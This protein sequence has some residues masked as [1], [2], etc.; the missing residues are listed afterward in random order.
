[1][2]M[3]Y[4]RSQLF[5]ALLCGAAA[6]GH[7][8]VPTTIIVPYPAGGAVDVL[9][10][11]LS[12]KM[13]ETSG[14]VFVIDNRPGS[15]GLI[16]AMA[17]AQAKPDGKTWLLG[18]D[19]LLTVNPFLYPKD[20]AFT[21]DKDLLVVRGLAQQQA[22]LFV[23]PGFPAKTMKE[24]VD[25]ARKNEVTYA[26]AGNGS[27]AHLTMELLGSAT[28]I[29]LLHVPY[30]GGNLAMIDVIAG[31]VQAS[32]AAVP[33]AIEHVKAGKVTPLAVAAG[34]RAAQLPNVPTTAEA[35]FPGLAAETAVFMMLPAGV[36]AD[37]V[38]KVNRTIAMALADAGVRERIVG[39]GWLPRPDMDTPMAQQWLARTTAI[40]S[41]LIPEKG[42]KAE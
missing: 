23:Y 40:W 11:I 10:R 25:Y 29:K 39:T 41:K 35:G 36:P 4:V 3:K 20:R 27:P 33:V 28:G 34:T 21:A 12:Q 13:T 32:F 16:G 37:T 8:Q 31:R 38:A 17:A 7:A 22:L 42:I 19:A 9:A 18:G 26:S 2:N 6:F 14:E 5:A 24:F 30:K 15:N 1:M